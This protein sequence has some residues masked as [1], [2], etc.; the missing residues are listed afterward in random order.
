MNHT[1][2]DLVLFSNGPGEISTWVRPVLD[3][4]TARPGLRERYRIVLIVHPC[5]FG[6]GTERL[7]STSLPGVDLF[8]GP[9]EYLRLLFRVPGAGKYDFSREGVIVSLGGDL[10]HPV[11]F[12]RRVRG[13]H[14]LFAYTN[15]TGWEKHY[16]RIF[17][18]SD[19]Q[20]RKFLDRGVDT[21]KVQVTGDL[22]HSSLRFEC[23]RDK[24]RQSLGLEDG[25]LL[26][27]FLPGSRGFEVENMLPVYLYV[28]DQ[29]SRLVPEAVPCVLKSPYAPW[30]MLERGLARGGRI[31]EIRSLPGV[32]HRS[33]ESCSIAYADEKKVEVLEGGLARYGCAVDLAVTLPGTNNV[34][35]AYRKIPSLV[36]APLNKLELIPIEGA[37][38]LLK[39]V[40][41]G[42][43]IL[44][45][46]VDKYVDRFRFASLPNLYEGEEIFPELFGVLTSEQIVSRL[47]ALI[48]S[49]EFQD[50][51]T[52][53]DRFS[54]PEEPVQRIVDEIWGENGDPG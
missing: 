39:W 45:K 7:V 10:M 49:G 33:P 30:E 38:G 35:L 50:V 16:Q 34:Q 44:R 27:A 24:I 19:Y 3:E 40:P 14:R 28:M 12:R 18:R 22:V 29:L 43:P 11:L 15:N 6:S 25:R 9:G 42:K 36:V 2:E 4:V 5:Q 54:F 32:L 47:A 31:K 41:L 52:R 51:R 37:A 1:G 17:V 46:A 26:V 48:R 53:L 21:E 8:L 23:S 13:G 20:K